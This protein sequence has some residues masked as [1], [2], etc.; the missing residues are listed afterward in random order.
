MSIEERVNHMEKKEFFDLFTKETMK[1]I[2]DLLY[3]WEKRITHLEDGAIKFEKVK[4]CPINK[5]EYK[6][7][8]KMHIKDIE[9]RF[10]RLWNYFKE[11]YDYRS[12]LHPVVNKDL[13]N[14]ISFTEKLWNYFEQKR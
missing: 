5:Y 9:P 11:N 12:P 3:V 14:Y 8:V 6:E 1:E 2:E 7:M 4:L 13:N 10:E